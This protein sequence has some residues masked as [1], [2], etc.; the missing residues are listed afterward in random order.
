MRSETSL[1]GLLCYGLKYT[2]SLI[3]VKQIFSVTASSMKFNMRSETS[4]H[5]LLCYGLKHTYSLILVEHVDLLCEH[6]FL[7]TL[8]I[9][10]LPVQ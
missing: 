3:L 10:Q 8:G 6:G 2:Y 9:S 5:T 4:L 7:L 1:H